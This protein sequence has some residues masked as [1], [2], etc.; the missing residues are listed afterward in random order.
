MLHHDGHLPLNRPVRAVVG[1][2]V[3]VC[4]RGQDAHFVLDSR[5][6]R[7]A[8]AGDAAVLNRHLLADDEHARLWGAE[9]PGGAVG[10]LAEQP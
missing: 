9:E 2:N 7:A 5:R 10:A 1:D 6:E 8:A 4:Q 3:R